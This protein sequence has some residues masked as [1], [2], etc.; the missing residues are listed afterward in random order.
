[1]K[2]LANVDDYVSKSHRLK[3]FSKPASV[4]LQIPKP[5]KVLTHQGFLD[6]KKTK[7]LPKTLKSEVA[8]YFIAAK[9]ANPHRGIYIGRGFYVPGMETPPGPRTGGIEDIELYFT[10]II[11]FYEFAINNNFDIPG[12]DIALLLHPFLNCY[13]PPLQ[14][15]PEVGYPGGSVT[16]SKDNINEIIIETVWGADEGIQ[17]LPHDSYLVDFERLLI[18]EKKIQTKTHALKQGMTSEYVEVRV[19]PSHS[20]IQVLNDLQIMQIAQDY[21]KIYNSLGNHRVEFILQPEGVIY[22][23]CTPFKLF[24]DSKSIILTNKRSLVKVIAGIADLRNLSKDIEI[25]AIDP[26]VIKS[27]SME[28]L[29]SLAVNA[30]NKLIV[31]YPGTATTAHSAT[32][33]REQGHT[34][35]YTQS[36]SFN[37]GD[38]V[39]VYIENGDLLV[40]VVDA[41]SI[42]N[43]IKLNE[44]KYLNIA[45]T[46]AKAFRLFELHQYNIP[47]P[48]TM[49]VNSETFNKFIKSNELDML[50]KKLDTCKDSG[51]EKLCE[52]IKNEI[53]SA[54]LPKDVQEEIMTFVH[55]TRLK[56][57]A[58]RSSANCEDSGKASFAG[59]F[60]SFSPVSKGQILE[61]IKLVWASTYNPGAIRYGLKNNLAPSAFSMAVIIQEFIKAEKAGVLFTKDLQTK[62]ANVMVIEAVR[63]HGEKVVNGTDRVEK[64]IVNKKSKLVKASAKSPEAQKGKTILSPTDIKT[65][66]KYANAIENL[67]KSEQDI[68]W[69]IHDDTVVI[70]QTR[71]ITI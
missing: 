69:A 26:S 5:M 16:P 67:Y 53:L 59:Q 30:P 64:V 13:L 18:I 22:R 2:Y 3:G 36:Q 70:L 66:A 37:N 12:S 35:V 57:F 45:Y 38:F 54:E 9:K 48:I 7:Q 62:D 27:R 11:K 21:K 17:T 71:P 55:A 43:I 32:V 15:N 1:M 20:A 49:V 46:G 51:I 31:L 14:V 41:A 42:P 33:F 8:K 61:N 44:S 52:R 24:N 56:Q 6:Y 28:V 47:I 40:K 19:P 23:E 63:G 10:E 68:E 4:G 25:V 58:I 29:T 65:L 50:I 39:E 60:D 34:L